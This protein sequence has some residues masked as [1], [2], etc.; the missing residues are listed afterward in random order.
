[1]DNNIFFRIA[2][3]QHLG[4]I[5]AAVQRRAERIRNNTPTLRDLVQHLADV[6]G[7][8]VVGS[9]NLGCYKIGYGASLCSVIG[10]HGFY[11]FKLDVIMFRETDGNRELAE[12]LRAQFKAKSCRIENTSGEWFKL[13]DADLET[14]RTTFQFVSD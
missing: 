5:K 11:P 13:N 10:S 8:Y 2:A 1:M 9:L 6:C 7:V 4:Y 14:L 12:Q 3:E